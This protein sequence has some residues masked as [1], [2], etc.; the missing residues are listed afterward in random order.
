MENEYKIIS[1]NIAIEIEQQEVLC[2]LQSINQ[3]KSMNMRFFMT[4]IV[5]VIMQL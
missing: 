1:L 5:D 3:L 4:L 2:K